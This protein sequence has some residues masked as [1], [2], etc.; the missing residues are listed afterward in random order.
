RKNV[1]ESLRQQVYV[2]HFPSSRAGEVVE[3]KRFGFSSYGSDTNNVYAPFPSQRDYLFAQW[4]K[5]RG[6]SSTAL[7]ELLRIDGVRE[8]L[9]LA[10]KNTRELNKLVDQLPSGR[11]RFRCKQLLVGG[12]VLEVYY[13]DVLECVESLYGDPNFAADMIYTPERHYAD[14]DHTI[15]VYHEVHTGKWWWE[16]QKAIE[17][18]SPGGTIV[19]IIISSDKTKLTTFKGKSAYPVYLTIANIPKDI[20]RKPSHHAQI[21]LA[22]LPTSRL[23]HIKNKASRRRMNANLF[24]AC[25]RK[26]LS[27]LERAGLDGKHMTSGDGAVRRCH[28]IYAAHV[29]DYPE[30]VLVTGVKSGECPGCDAPKDDL[31]NHTPYPFRNLDAV[32]KALATAD[33]I[34]RVKACAAAGI[35]PIFRP[36]WE[37]L[38]YTNIFLA[39]TPDILHQ[40][41]QGVIKHLVEWV[42]LAYGASEIDAR[43]SRLPPNHHVRVFSKGISSLSQLT[44]REH[45]DICRI[46]LGLIIDMPLPSGISPSR[47]VCAVRAVLD[48]LYIAQ[49]PV[50]TSETLALLEDALDRFHENKEIFEELKI[51]TGW[52]IPKLHYLDHYGFLIKWLG[53]PD[54]FNT[55]YTERLHIEFAKDA[56]EA[57]NSKDE[58]PQ[59]T[60]W[61]ERKEKMFRHTKYVEWCLAG[62]PPLAT[63]LLVD[64]IPPERIKMTK[65]PSKSMVVFDK[66][67]SDYGATFIREALARYIVQQNHPEYTA[68]EVED[69]SDFGL[70]FRGL[71]VYHKAKFWLGD[72]QNYRLSSNEWDVVHATPARNTKRGRLVNGQFD[73]A[74]VNDGDGTYI[75]IDGYRV[76]QV[77]LI[78]SLPKRA[79]P[80]FSE[81]RQPPKYLAY[82]E[83]F[84]DFTFPLDDHGLYKIKRSLSPVGERLASI[85]PLSSIRRSVYLFPE[86]GPVVNRD[87]TSGDILENCAAYYVDCFS[88]RHAYHTIL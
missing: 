68:R 7:D 63:S 62:R 64:D 88:D 54:N 69:M 12:E 13:R 33:P 59:M 30:Q 84:K 44:G 21:L 25:M 26:I 6:P 55:E 72:S 85:I 18:K 36:Y 80:L 38:P 5:N 86:F 20:R 14:P 19:P 58:L 65:H 28:P 56:Y 75:G 1:E 60:L 53:T 10:F 57:T 31:G 76:A 46:L 81:T 2:E 42:T 82:V 70:P 83:W 43:A 32:C 9:G 8:D 22:Y 35:K 71:P 50:Q 77:R 51:R 67:I 87:W 23:E 61:L 34:Q 66:L 41:Y 3:T 73:T 27:P 74:L 48:F 24:H 79:A 11:P 49:Y 37:D 47:L 52:S 16:V 15:R 4:A 17:R 29:G 78:F 45:A 39:I 40:L